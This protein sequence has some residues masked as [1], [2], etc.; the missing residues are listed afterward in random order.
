MTEQQILTDYKINGNINA[1]QAL[2]TMH[3][4]FVHSMVSKHR[5][6]SNNYEDLVQEGTLG[7]IHAINKFDINRPIK[8]ISYAVYWIRHYIARYLKSQNK[9]TA[10]NF[11]DEWIDDHPSPELQVVKNRLHEKIDEAAYIVLRDADSR[12]KEIF[13]ARYREAEEVSFR[14]LGERY[15][16]SRQRAKQ[17][18][19]KTIDKIRMEL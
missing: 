19:S 16:I 17:I 6:T 14:E 3:Q 10:V 15:G 13:E 2:V 4:G 12:E 1:L 8:L 11:E 9:Y 7:L 18:S 5:P